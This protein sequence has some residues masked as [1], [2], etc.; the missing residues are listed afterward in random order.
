VYVSMC[1]SS[2]TPPKLDR[3]LKDSESGHD[4]HMIY[5]ICLVHWLKDSM[6]RACVYHVVS[7]IILLRMAF[8]CFSRVIHKYMLYVV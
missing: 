6:S 8:T 2:Q 5:D 7:L 4:M 3:V 1:V